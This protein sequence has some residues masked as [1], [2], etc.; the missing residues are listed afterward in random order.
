[1]RAL[2]AGQERRDGPLV[3]V[4]QHSAAETRSPSSSASI[5][6]VPPL[7]LMT[8]FVARCTNF[9]VSRILRWYAVQLKLEYLIDPRRLRPASWPVW[10][11]RRLNSPTM[12]TPH[13]GRRSRVEDLDICD[14]DV[15]RG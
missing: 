4:V 12:V 13:V 8:A 14:P 15:G 3:Q 5:T 2:R 10:H 7:E 11:L 6:L 1:M 9:C